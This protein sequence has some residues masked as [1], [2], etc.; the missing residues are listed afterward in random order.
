[1]GI[2]GCI[3]WPP[4]SIGAARTLKYD[5]HS[6]QTSLEGDDFGNEY[7]Y[8]GWSSGALASDGVIYCISFNAKQVLSIDPFG[9]FLATTK[10]NM[11]EHPE[12][13]RSLFQTIEADED[14]NYDLDGNYNSDEDEH[15]DEVSIT[16]LTNFE[17]AVIKFG[18]NMFEV[19]EKAIKPMNDYCKKSNLY[20]FMITASYKEGPVCAINHLLRHDLSWVNSCISGLGG[21]APKSKRI[22]IN[23][24]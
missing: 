7:T 21:K 24:M 5:P 2:D 11:Q 22:R 9:E 10:A 16:S 3:Y 8:S 4:S 14:S 20:P 17:L 6:N 12:E 13:F 23:L 18:Q 15:E 1:M 19:L